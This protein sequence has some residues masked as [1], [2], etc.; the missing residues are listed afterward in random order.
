MLSDL[1]NR[2][3]VVLHN[4]SSVHRLVELVRL[5]AGFGI[6]NIVLTKVTGA[7][8]QQGLPEVFKIGLKLNTNIIVLSELNEVVDLLAPT[9]LFFLTCETGQLTLS[10]LVNEVKT[11]EGKIGLVV[12]GSDLPFLPRELQLGK[13]VKVTKNQIPGTGVLAITLYKILEEHS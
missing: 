12:N 11:S 7:A 9:K 1:L 10:D 2:V 8:A 3:I 4:I 13:S 5:A 6:K